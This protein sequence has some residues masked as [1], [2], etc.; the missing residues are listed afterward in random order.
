MYSTTA[1]ITVNEI[2]PGS[3]TEGTGQNVC[4]SEMPDQLGTSA[5]VAVTIGGNAVYQWYKNDS[6]TWEEI[7]D[8]TETVY[9]P[10]PLTET[11]SYKR[12]ITNTFNGFVCF[13]ET[14]AVSIVVTSV[15]SGGTATDQNICALDELQL[16][17]I[18]NGETNA[19]FQ[20]QK[21]NAGI[22]EDISGATQSF[23]DANANLSGGISEF[24]RISTVSGASC[25]GISTV[26]TITYTNFSEG[27][28][29]TNETICYDETPQAFSS[30]SSANGS[31]TISYQWESSIDNGANWSIVSGASSEVYQSGNLQQT[32]RYR[33]L[34]AVTLNGFTCSDY[35]NEVIISVLEEIS[36]G[37]VSADQ[38]ICE[39]EVPA[40]LTV[41][42]GTAPGENITYQWQSKTNGNFANMV[43]ETGESLGF[44]TAPST[45]TTYRRET[46]ISDNAQICTAFSTESVVFVNIIAAGII[47]SDQTICSGETVDQL[48]SLSSANAEGTISYQWESSDDNGNSWNSIPSATNATYAPTGIATTT[49]FRRLDTSTLNGK[50]CQEHTNEVSITVAGEIDGGS[51]SADQT[52]CEAELPSTL[53]ITGGT[54]AA[55]D[56][57]FQWFSSPN[58]INYTILSGETSETLEFSSGIAE[59]TYFKREVTRT[60][61]ANTC[62][63]FSTPTLITLLSLSAGEIGDTQ[64]V[65]GDVNVSTITSTV[66]PAS[67]GTVSY[68]W[69]T[70]FDGN[71]WSAVSGAN[72]STYTPPITDDLVRYFRRKASST[73]NSITCEATTVPVIVICKPF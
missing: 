42:N 65:C 63:T 4:A 46:I 73:I 57:D 49:L 38:T 33:R 2:Y 6:G 28:I 17:T 39:S 45:T 61:G 27:S 69:E 72:Q 22:W 67:N 30:N 18:N 59:T 21:N 60:T 53:S 26:A 3:I 31:G 1:E 13:E 29:G 71:T 15:V 7:S 44:A 19:D 20:W 62:T 54:S 34:D 10:G 14:A 11:T 37:D 51:S 24:R 70:S 25:E 50:I 41:N 5:D 55:A 43:G 47:G 8:A 36:G 9:Q 12:R 23:Y 52:V 40:T 68:E 32:T 48:L 16:L 35:T 66:D 58:D 64:T 56:I